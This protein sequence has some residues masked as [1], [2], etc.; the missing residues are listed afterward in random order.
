MSVHR[1]KLE[2][3]RILYAG[4]GVTPTVRAVLDVTEGE[5]RGR[6]IASQTREGWQIQTARVDCHDLCDFDPWACLPELVG[7]GTV[8]AVRLDLGRDSD[9]IQVAHYLNHE[10]EVAE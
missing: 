4:G 8:R 1:A 3:G 6:L 2:R 9:F 10:P 7:A 5:H